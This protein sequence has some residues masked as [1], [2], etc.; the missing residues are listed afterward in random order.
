[1]TIPTAEFE[2]WTVKPAALVRLGESVC[3]LGVVE[4]IERDE[5]GFLVFSFAGRSG[6]G[7]AA[8][9]ATG[10]EPRHVRLVWA[11][12][13]PVAVLSACECGAPA[14]VPCPGEPLPCSRPGA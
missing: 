8:W 2:G 7:S 11:V 14:G 10:R 3:S 12:D 5:D 9:E 13:D 6:V 1:V 4:A